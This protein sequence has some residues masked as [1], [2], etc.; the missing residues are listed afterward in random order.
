MTTLRAYC[1]S[2]LQKFKNLE[3]RINIKND[4]FKLIPRYN[5]I[6]TALDHIKSSLTQKKIDTKR[7]ESYENI[8]KIDDCSNIKQNFNLLQPED[9]E[10]LKSYLDKN[11]IEKMKNKSLL[12]KKAEDYIYY[13]YNLYA[14]L[15]CKKILN[16]FEEINNITKN[17]TIEK[18]NLLH[19]FLG[20]LK[21]DKFS[22]LHFFYDE[23]YIKSAYS[24]IIRIKDKMN[25]LPDEVLDTIV[26]YKKN[27]L[28]DA[29]NSKPDTNQLTDQGYFI[30]R[31]TVFN[32]NLITFKTKATLKN[33]SIIDIIFF[34]SPLEKSIDSFFPTFDSFDIYEANISTD[35]YEKI[36]EDKSYSQ[37]MN[38]TSQS[39]KEIK[40]IL[41][42]TYNAKKEERDKNL[43]PFTK[44]SNDDDSLKT[45]IKDSNL[46]DLNL[47]LNINI[48]TKD[49]FK[50]LDELI[51]KNS[52][53]SFNEKLSKEKEEKAANSTATTPSKS[54]SPTTTPSKSTSILGDSN[55]MVLKEK[56]LL[57]VHQQAL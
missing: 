34:Y 5:H 4:S 6:S 22:G 42:K 11:M 36:N 8:K 52:F 46:E 19:V 12:T 33:N 10:F 44:E 54:I 51:E 49:E 57:S 27:E 7:E 31:C 1:S 50:Q 24:K 30:K 3:S 56:P 35:D 2:I 41:E 13:G 9:Y 55:S 39:F 25:P 17:Y 48:L 45:D 43:A 16:E 18:W 53:D 37:F 32:K 38:E 21:N 40:D 15:S 23:K 26:F 47:P 14:T 28:F 20:N 29:S